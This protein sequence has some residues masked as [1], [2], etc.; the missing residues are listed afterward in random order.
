MITIARL[1]RAVP[2]ARGHA[3]ARRRKFSPH[4]VVGTERTDGKAIEGDSG[5]GQFVFGARL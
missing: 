5:R 3:V 2:G 1:Q 4:L